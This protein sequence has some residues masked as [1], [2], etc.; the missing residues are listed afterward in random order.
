MKIQIERLKRL[1]RRAN[2]TWQGGLTRLPMWVEDESNEKPY[3]PWIGGWISIQTKLIHTSAPVP[4]EEKSFETALNVLVDFACNSELAG[5]RPGKIEVK[6]PA[7]AEYL[8]SIL[9]EADIA[10][11]VRKKLFTFDEM[12]GEMAEKIFERPMLPDALDSKGVTV[13]SMRSFADAACAFYKA[14]P[15][16]QLACDDLI[17]IESPF[18]DASL[19]YATVL[20]EIGE[21]FGLGFYESPE[22]L[23]SILEGDGAGFLETGNHWSV[24]FGPMVE[25]P[26]GDVDLWE[27]HDLPVASE[28]GYP[29]ATCWVPDGKP[30]RPGPDILAFFEGLLRVLTETTE[31]QMNSGRW[32]KNVNTAQ[33]P[34]EFTLTLPNLAAPQE[35][36]ANVRGQAGVGPVNMRS[37]ERVTFD[38]HRM[39]EGHEFESVEKM[40]EF[41]Q[42]KCM[43]AEAPRAALNTAMEKA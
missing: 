38:M 36:N 3:R 26:F 30:R 4:P 5:Y 33:G 11:A 9:A 16:E 29:L 24:L 39:L 31:E 27:D 35:E 23:E 12:I 13:E 20:G 8:G 25:L 14:R 21:S 42:D 28:D 2:E 43:G 1:G 32:Q 41:L 40:N 7:L 37:M 22:Q 19:R 17:E 10:V 34:M 15:W 6:D 18:V